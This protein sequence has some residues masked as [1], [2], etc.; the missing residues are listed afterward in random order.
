MPGYMNN[1]FPPKFK[2]RSSFIL[3]VHRQ[4]VQKNSV[5]LTSIGSKY[6]G[7]TLVIKDNLSGFSG[8]GI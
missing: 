6:S 3:W 8:K 5:I 4:N 2:D 1:S 7:S